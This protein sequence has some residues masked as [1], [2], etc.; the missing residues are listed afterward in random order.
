MS[1]AT[2]VQVGGGREGAA[3][4]APDRRHHHEPRP[5][6]GRRQGAGAGDGRGLRAAAAARVRA[7]RARRASSA[8]TWPPQGFARRGIATPHDVVVSGALASVLSGGEHGHHRHGDRGRDCWSWNARQFMRLVRDHA[9]RSP[10]SSTCWRPASRCATDGQRQG[11][12]TTIMQTYTA[13]AA[14]HALRAARAARHARRSPACRA[15]RSS[16]PS[17]DRQRAGGGGQARPRGAAADQRQRRRRRLPARERRGAHAGGLPRGLRQFREGGWTALARRPGTM[18]ARAC[19]RAV[20]KLVE[21]MICAANISFSL[22]PG[23]THG[24]YQ[25]ARGPCARR[26]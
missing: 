20:N 9:A 23:L 1:T 11:T 24:A 19:P 26:S 16:R 2:V 15:S 10:A 4:P 22:Y 25:R 14:R 3:V 5:P 18:A 8:W 6:A 12:G 17:S 21:E 13:P 7:A